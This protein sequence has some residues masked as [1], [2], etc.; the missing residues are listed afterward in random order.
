MPT[1]HREL[2]LKAAKRLLRETGYANITA[3]DLVAASDT[4]LG[5]IGYHFG[6]KD[7][8]LHEAMGE[9][10]TEWTDRV[11]DEASAET[12]PLRRAASSWVATLNSMP[13]HA[14]L[15][16]AFIDS[17][18]PALRSPELR[19]QLAQQYRDLRAQVGETVSASLEGVSEAEAAAIASF[20]I[21]IADGFVIQYL[22]EPEDCPTG[23]ELVGA[24]GAALAAASNSG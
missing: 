13:E 20:F 19:A 16:Q 22:L 14:P 17:L 21:A 12:D 10:F 11:T 18:G 2:L 1:G 4:N 6:S 3:R 7:A 8:L 5:S 24:L 9:V 23:E 15:L